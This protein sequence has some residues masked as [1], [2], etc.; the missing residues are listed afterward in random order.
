M[1]AKD[2]G[3]KYS[4][5]KC[6]A[7][8]YDLKKPEPVCPKCGSDQRESPPQRPLDKAERRRAAARPAVVE[9]PALE[10]EA[11]EEEPAAGE[12][13]EAEVPERDEEDF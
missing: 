12:E 10:E 7:K 13:D 8:F 5:F 2:L 1:A 3:T 4:C 6:G 11:L 9:E